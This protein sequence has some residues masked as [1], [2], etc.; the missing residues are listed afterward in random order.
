MDG[1]KR[2]LAALDRWQRR[3]RWVGPAWAVNKKFGDDK[4]NLYVVALGW[5]GFTA[6]YPLLLVAISILGFIGQASLGHSTLATLQK[7]PVIGQQFTPGEGGKQLH[8]SVLG[9]VI[10]LAGLLY[11]AQGVTQT[12][13]QTMARCW[14]VPE[15]ARPGFL[16]RMGRSFTGLVL[17][18][19]AFLVTAVA[20]SFAT[21]HNEALYVRVPVLAVLLAVNT[22]FYM[23]TFRALTPK[24]APTRAL[25]P[26][27]AFGAVCFTALTTIGTGLVSHELAGKSATYGAFASVIGVVA[28]LLLLAK[29]S[30]YGAELN[31]VLHRRLWPRALPT[32]EPT[33]ADQQVLHDLAHEQRALPEQRIG[34]GFD[35]CAPEEARLDAE[36]SDDE[37][38]Q[39]ELDEPAH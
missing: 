26:G 36:Q 9:L 24:E 11:G 23:A 31:P 38:R 20:G 22:A 29:L 18:G 30:V 19:G 5:Y 21:A 14:N 27:A 39:P 10:G 1:I 3:S 7:F 4:A 8:G 17:I 15:V 12:A 34:V 13:Q 16:P 32:S 25:L 6:I 35:E 33:R 37:G 28:F 2:A